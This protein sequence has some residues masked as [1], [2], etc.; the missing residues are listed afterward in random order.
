M[1]T[2]NS[3]ES[4]SD[5]EEPHK[6]ISRYNKLIDANYRSFDVTHRTRKKWGISY[7]NKSSFS[8]IEEEKRRQETSKCNS[9]LDTPLD[10]ENKSCEI[11]E[12]GTSN[13]PVHFDAL[14]TDTENSFVLQSD[15]SLHDDYNEDFNDYYGNSSDTTDK[16]NSNAEKDEN[17]NGHNALNDIMFESSQLSIRYVIVMITAFS[18][19]YHLSNEAQVELAALLK[20][21]ADG[22]PLTRSGKKGFWPAQL[23]LNDLSHKLRFRFVLLSGL[24]SVTK[25]P[26]STFL[27][28]YLQTVLLDQIDN[29]NNAR[30]TIK[31]GDKNIYLRFSIHSCVVDTVCRPI[32]QNRVSFNGYSGC[33]YCYQKGLYLHSVYGIRYVVT[34]ESI[35]RTHK[36]HEND[37]KEAVNCNNAVRGVKG[38]SCFQKLTNFDMVWSFSYEYMHSLLSSVTYEIWNEWKCG[39]SI[40]KLSN[41]QIESIE[42]RYINITPTHDIHRLP[43]SG[44][45]HGKMKPKASEIRFWLLYSSL[46]CLRGILHDN[47]LNHYI[48]HVRSAY[49]LLKSEIS[50]DELNKCEK[51][52]VRFVCEYEMLYGQQSLTF[53]L[54][55]LLHAV[56]STVKSGPLHSNSAFPFES[57]IF[58]LKINVRV[59]GNG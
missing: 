53:N 47:A 44:I 59:Y 32:I 14:S 43:R 49:I 6:K 29:L 33:S 36:S 21:C 3:D 27:N 31:I 17:I 46:P 35:N 54:H 34:Q 39:K 15:E 30:I 28:L 18:I 19:R 48:L 12:S 25:E 52:I 8:T 5:F 41:K 37:I 38:P 1:S 4:T 9:N 2:N 16:S 58:N 22:A 11:N 56:N 40:Y 10:A 57:N 13:S 50:V 24:M 45:L 23:I 42:M 55:A 26:K 20:I 51:D 7:Q